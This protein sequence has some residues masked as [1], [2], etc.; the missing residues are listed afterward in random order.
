VLKLARGERVVQDEHFGLFTAA[1]IPKIA[2]IRNFQIF[3][4][5]SK[6]NSNI[7]ETVRVT[8]ILQETKNIQNG[9]LRPAD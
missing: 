5:I 4:A 7:S 1:E 8:K 6:K 3:Y 9:F 2:E